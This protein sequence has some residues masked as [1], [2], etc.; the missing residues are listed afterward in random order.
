MDVFISWTSADLDVKN[1]IAKRLQ[2]ENISFFDSDEDCVSDYSEECI[3]AIRKCGLFIVLVSDASMHRGYVI[4]E[5]I[6]ARKCED[7][8][9]LNILMGCCA[10]SAGWDGL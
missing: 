2:E 1:T 5:V 7:A 8:G 3:Q 4:N 6:E 9:R 10:R